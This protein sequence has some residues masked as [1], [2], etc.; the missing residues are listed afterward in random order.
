MPK[1]G[2]PS[3]GRRARGQADTPAPTIV[4][5]PAEF[6]RA[7]S[8]DGER[9]RLPVPGAQTVGRRAALRIRL[10]GLGVYA[11]VTG[12]VRAVWR[13]RGSAGVELAPDAHGLRAARWLAAAARGEEVPSRERAR[14]HF[15][16]LPVIVTSGGA[17][18]FTTTLNVSEGGCALKWSGELPSVGEVVRLRLGANLRA[19]EACF[20]VRWT[21]AARPGRVGLRRADDPAS[22]AAWERL[23]TSS[24]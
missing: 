16:E 17:G 22:A 8:A 20:E 15:L 11:A 4:L 6:I 10:V 23:L 19:S 18:T 14:R 2:K 3:Q 12:V 24:R 1:G 9:L 13:E 7:L 21:D 5:Q